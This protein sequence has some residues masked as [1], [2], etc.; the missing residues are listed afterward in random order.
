MPELSRET[1]ALL[2][3]LE[4]RIDPEVEDEYISGWRDFLLDRFEGDIFVPKR[5]RFSEPGVPLK[6]IRINQAIEDYDAMLYAQMAV[7][8][9]NLSPK[10]ES[11]RRSFNLCMRANYGT[12]ILSSLFGAELFMM[13]DEADT[14]PTTKPLTGDDAMERMLAG[15]IPDFRKGLGEKVFA[16]AE[17]ASEILKDYPKISKYV[18]VYHPDLQGPLDICDL[19]FGEKMFYAFYD[20]PELL[21]GVLDLITETYTGFL[22]EWH[23]YFPPKPDMNPHWDSLWHR[24]TI[25][26]RNDSA[27]NLSPDVYEEFSVPYDAKLLERF[28]GGAMHFCG[29]GDHYIE[30]LCRIPGLYAVNMSQPHLN[31][32][33]KIYRNT[34]DKGI[35]LVGFDA[36]WAE[37]DRARGYNHNLSL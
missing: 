18:T 7:A 33:E 12:G 35:K 21:H 20:D 37:K 1:K 4:R 22:K 34:V 9:S 27:M 24:G 14:L 8:S 30:A 19:L 6:H 23:G 10:M 31:D 2:D 36:S 15:G 5:K 11:A 3:D 17:F 13:A 25:L 28:G 29:R 16:F 32:M 26:L